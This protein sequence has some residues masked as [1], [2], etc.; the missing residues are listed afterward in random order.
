MNIALGGN[1]HQDLRP[2]RQHTPNRNSIFRIKDALLEPDSKLHGIIGGDL[3]RVNSLHNQAIRDIAGPFR[4]AATDRDGFTQ[5]IEHPQREFTIG[6]Q[7][8]P[9]Y[10][11]Y[12]AQHRRLFGA[13]ARA[14]KASHKILQGD[15]GEV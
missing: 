4:L 15:G 11:P 2:L 12:A 5:A 7:W 6:V 8:H 1:L 13:F 9:E 3:L 14:V 10:L